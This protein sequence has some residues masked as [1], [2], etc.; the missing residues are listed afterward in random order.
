MSILLQP[1]GAVPKGTAPFYRLIT[2]AHFANKLYSDCG[3]TYTTAAQLSSTLNRC[4]YHF[5]IDISDSYHSALWSDPAAGHHV[6]R[7]GSSRHEGRDEVTW[8]EKRLHAVHVP[9]WL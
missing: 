2:D 1:C 8:I 4:D 9:R 7:A 3:V 6:T 5:F